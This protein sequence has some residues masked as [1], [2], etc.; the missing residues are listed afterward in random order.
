MDN[1]SMSVEQLWENLLSRQPDLVKL[2]FATLDEEEQA[3]VLA[4][5]NKMVTE[6]GWHLEQRRSAEVALAALGMVSNDTKN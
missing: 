4:H 6:S 2:A 5:L 3:A 1:A